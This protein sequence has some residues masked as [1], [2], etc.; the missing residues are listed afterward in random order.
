MESTIF[1]NTCNS[2]QYFVWFG[3]EDFTINCVSEG[4]GYGMMI[5]A[6]MAGYNPDAKTIYDGL[7]NYYRAHLDSISYEL[8]AWEQ[9]TAC[10]DTSNADDA[11]DGDMDIAYSLLLANKQWG[12]TGTI[13]YLQ[14][15]NKMIDSLMAFVINKHSHFTELGD[16]ADTNNYSS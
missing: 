5:A 15:A 6:Y 8:M 12:S 9:N 16:W 2:G 11:T 10:I 13:N 4:Q 14:E 7:Y 1:R 3:D